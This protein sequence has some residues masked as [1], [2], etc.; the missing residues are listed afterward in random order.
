M[1]MVQI[2]TALHICRMKQQSAKEWF[3]AAKVR[4]VSE[5][6]HCNLQYL[7]FELTASTKYCAF[8]FWCGAKSSEQ[9]HSMRL[10]KLAQEKDT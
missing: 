9:H 8:D 3:V 4:E 7:R 10:V 6:I 5:H 1:Q 2:I